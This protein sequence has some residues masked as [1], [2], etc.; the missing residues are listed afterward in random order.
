MLIH[1]AGCQIDII[2]TVNHI[3]WKLDS[4][5][6][7]H[8]LHKVLSYLSGN[9]TFLTITMPELSRCLLQ[10]IKYIR[11]IE[12]HV[13]FLIHERG[14]STFILDYV[15]WFRGCSLSWHTSLIVHRHYFSTQNIRQIR[16]FDLLVLL[17]LLLPLRSTFKSW[18]LIL[19]EFLLSHLVDL[20]I[21]HLVFLMRLF[22]FDRV[23]GFYIL[24][25]FIVH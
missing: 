11:V 5:L 9:T 12:F 8:V 10:V 1:E 4:R 21:M 25:E 19:H 20:N 2:L 3:H 23:E 14:T 7:I 6:V 17:L 24:D 16:Y 22:E 13:D 15:Y 18:H